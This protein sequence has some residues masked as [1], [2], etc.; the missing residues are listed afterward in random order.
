MKIAAR[1]RLDDAYILKPR[2]RIRSLEPFPKALEISMDFLGV[3][4]LLGICKR[5]KSSLKPP[6]QLC[7]MS[8]RSSLKI[9]FKL[10]LFL[11]GDS[12]RD[13]SK[14]SPNVTKFLFA[15]YLP[16]MYSVLFTRLMWQAGFKR[17]AHHVD[18][19]VSCSVYDIYFHSHFTSCF[20]FCMML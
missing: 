7:V 14:T 12:F 1:M 20:L 15:S 11:I 13:V 19:P 17:R 18:Y 6:S 4:R 5:Y 8:W 2:V 3:V 9:F 16:F 10:R